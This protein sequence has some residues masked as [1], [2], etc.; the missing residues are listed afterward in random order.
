MGHTHDTAHWI[1]Q[2]NS[3]QDTVQRAKSLGL[4][5]SVQTQISQWIKKS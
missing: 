5:G 4:T 3:Q 2:F 1:S